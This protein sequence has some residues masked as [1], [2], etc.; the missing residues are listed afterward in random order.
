VLHRKLERFASKCT[1]NLGA[2]SAT[3]FVSISTFLFR[4]FCYS[5]LA[6]IEKVLRDDTDV[7]PEHFGVNAFRKGIRFRFDLVAH[8][9]RFV[10]VEKVLRSNIGLFF[11]HWPDAQSF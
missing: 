4:F 10:L 9:S 5:D 1:E 7:M 6:T 8:D 2:L 3:T 11:C